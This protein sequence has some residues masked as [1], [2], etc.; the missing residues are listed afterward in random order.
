MKNFS[1]WFAPPPDPNFY[2]RH[3]KFGTEVEPPETPRA[4]KIGGPEPPQGAE[5]GG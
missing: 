5:I 2:R 3:V 1:K 4:K